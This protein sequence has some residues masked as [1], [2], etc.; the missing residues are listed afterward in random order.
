MTRNFKLAALAA[1]AFIACA[2]AFAAEQAAAPVAKQLAAN[3]QAGKKLNV[4]A[5][6][7]YDALA[8]FDPVSASESGDNRFIDQIGMTISPLERAKQFAR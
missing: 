3:P 4:L 1:A 2:P 8:R 5:D 7:Y 6:E